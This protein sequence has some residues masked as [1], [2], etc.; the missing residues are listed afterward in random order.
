MTCMEMKRSYPSDV[1]TNDPDSSDGSCFFLQDVKWPDCDFGE[2][3]SHRFSQ[4]RNTPPEQS[5]AQSR[6]RRNGSL[7][8]QAISVWLGQ[9]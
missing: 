9:A 6:G 7:P 2:R 8:R 4:F 1:D 3:Y 5:G